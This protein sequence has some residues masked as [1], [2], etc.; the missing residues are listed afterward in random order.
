[1]G[2][3]HA[4]EVRAVFFEETKVWLRIWVNSKMLAHKLQV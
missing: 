3:Q 4:N 2:T 1:M